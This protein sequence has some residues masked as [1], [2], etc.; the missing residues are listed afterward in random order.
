MTI[1]QF[2]RFESGNEKFILNDNAYS[3][4]VDNV[5]IL[6]AGVKHNNINSDNTLAPLKGFYNFNNSVHSPLFEIP[7][8]VRQIIEEDILKNKYSLEDSN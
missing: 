1:D 3:A 4:K 6:S 5:I 8:L 7:K 2:F